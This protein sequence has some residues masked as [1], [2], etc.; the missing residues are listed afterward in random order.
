MAKVVDQQNAGDPNYQPMARDFDSL[1]A[2][3]TARA[4]VRELHATKRLP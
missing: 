1:L 2:F 4:H 3:Q